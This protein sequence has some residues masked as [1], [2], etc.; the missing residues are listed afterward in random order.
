MLKHLVN[1]Y[2][3]PQKIRMDNGPEFIAALAQT[4]S[5]VNGIEFK[6][7]EPDK[8]TQNALVERFNRTYRQNDETEKLQ[9]QI[10]DFLKQRGR[11]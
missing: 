9:N 5:Q 4:W 1:R 3:K 7:I 6:H 8:P 11:H 2:G 10:P